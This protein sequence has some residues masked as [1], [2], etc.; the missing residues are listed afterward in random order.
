[1]SYERTACYSPAGS[2]PPWL[3]ISLGIGAS[4]TLLCGC[5]NG[6]GSPPVGDRPVTACQGTQTMVCDVRWPSK[7][8]HNQRQ[9]ACV[10]E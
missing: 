2:R 9:Y 1:M 6:S 5:A 10:C 3:R 7:L 8:R 4:L